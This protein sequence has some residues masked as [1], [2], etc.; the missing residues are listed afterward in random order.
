MPVHYIKEA[1]SR[2]IDIYG[3]YLVLT[4]FNEGGE[5]LFDI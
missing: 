4:I 3:F 5:G 2:D 1:S